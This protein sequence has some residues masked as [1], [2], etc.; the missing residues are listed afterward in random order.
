[1]AI[2]VFPTQTLEI[3]QKQLQLLTGMGLVEP[4]PGSTD[5]RGADAEKA[6][7]VMA[8]HP[9]EMV[10]DICKGEPVKME[11]PA[12]DFV[13]MQAAGFTQ[14]SIQ[15]WMLCDPCSEIMEDARNTREQIVDKLVSRAMGQ[16][17]DF[18]VPEL[19][20]T[21]IAL[22]GLYR[23]FLEHRLGPGRRT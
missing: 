17:E 2:V 4:V 12:E 23:S 6:L 7:A 11:Y 16:F 9:A 14:A 10:C 15:S 18:Q 1:M 21:D 20:A 19:L 3:G 8:E 13:M 5:F 22:H